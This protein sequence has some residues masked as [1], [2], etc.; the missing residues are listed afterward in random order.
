RVPK[1]E[2]LSSSRIKMSGHVLS[3]ALPKKRLERSNN[4]FVEN[5]QEQSAIF[6]RRFLRS[7]RLLRFIACRVL[8]DQQRAPMAIEKGWLTA[9]RNPLHFEYEGA[10]RSWLVRVLIDE[11]LVI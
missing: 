10:F 5:D 6:A 3:G 2:R 11:A 4:S 9:S 8:G 1:T 7:Y